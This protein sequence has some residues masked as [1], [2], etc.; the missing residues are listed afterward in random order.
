MKM[1]QYQELVS[2]YLVVPRL[3]LLVLPVLVTVVVK[4]VLPATL[5][6]TRY[7][8]VLVIF[9][10]LRGITVSSRFCCRIVTTRSGTM[11]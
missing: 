1:V 5:R 10:N 6:S 8:L 9:S 2:Y 11:L 3:V 7:Y 4:R